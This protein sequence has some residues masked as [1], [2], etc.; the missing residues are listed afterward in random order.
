MM[1]PLFIPDLI[2]RAIVAVVIFMAA[3][4]I[5]RTLFKSRKSKSGGCAGCDLRH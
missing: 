2:E 1:L 3:A 4:I 5:V